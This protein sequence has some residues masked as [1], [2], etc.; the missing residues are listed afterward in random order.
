MQMVSDYMFIKKPEANGINIFNVK[1]LYRK[2][3]FKDRIDINYA[4]FQRVMRYYYNTSIPILSVI[5][6]MVKMK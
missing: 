4:D 1:L 6:K 3:L 5:P 2:I